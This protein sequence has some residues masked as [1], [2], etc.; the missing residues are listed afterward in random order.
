MLKKAK[1]RIEL[2]IDVDPEFYDYIFKNANTE[3][4]LCESHRKLVLYTDY[5]IELPYIQ[6]DIEKILRIVEKVNEVY[7]T[8][9]YPWQALEILEKQGGVAVG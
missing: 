8:V 1:A 7:E 6:K 5:E 3:L 9:D 2:D 4:E